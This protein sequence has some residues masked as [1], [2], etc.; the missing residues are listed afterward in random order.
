MKKVLFIACLF[1]IM[2]VSA[3]FEKTN[4][5]SSFSDFYLN[6][7]VADIAGTIVSHIDFGS[8]SVECRPMNDGQA[9]SLV[10][11]MMKDPKRFDLSRENPNLICASTGTVVITYHKKQWEYSFLRDDQMEFTKGARVFTIRKK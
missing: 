1:S 8:D 4:F 6:S 10:S 3:Q 5:K 2:R 9:V 11:F 7:P